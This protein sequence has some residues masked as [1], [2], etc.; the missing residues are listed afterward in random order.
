MVWDHVGSGPVEAGDGIAIEDL[1]VEG[2]WNNGEALVIRDLKAH[3]LGQYRLSLYISTQGMGYGRPMSTV[4]TKLH[5]CRA[6][7][8]HLGTAERSVMLKLPSFDRET[9][10]E[11]V[12]GYL[13]FLAN[14]FQVSGRGGAVLACGLPPLPPHGHAGQIESHLFRGEPSEVKSNQ[15]NCRSS[16]RR[17]LVL[18]SGE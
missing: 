17:A 7:N 13:S 4:Y 16:V 8:G 6:Q 11:E 15:M 1:G 9:P 3:H 14:E 18:W 2:K 5:R 12:V 10:A